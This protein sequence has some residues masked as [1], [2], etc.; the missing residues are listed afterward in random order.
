M[1]ESYAGLERH[2]SSIQFDN[3]PVVLVPLCGKTRDLLWL[4]QHCRTVVGVEVSEVALREFLEENKLTAEENS[5]ADFKIFTTENII[6]WCGDFFHLPQQKLP[7]FDLIYDKAALVALP[8][9]KRDRYETK[10]KELVSEKTQILLHHFEYNQDEMNGPPFSV[11]PVEIERRFGS[12]FSISVLERNELDLDNYKK[13]QK[14]GL[15][16]NFIEYLSLLLPEGENN[17]I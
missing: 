16:G 9:S 5:F 3:D 7:V 11:P 6:L 2:W 10:L 17:R 12:L 13:F 15:Q 14:R 4:A 1:D 8:Y